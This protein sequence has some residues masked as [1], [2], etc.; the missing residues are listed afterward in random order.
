MWFL[1]F[2]IIFVGIFVLYFVSRRTITQ[3]TVTHIVSCQVPIDS[4]P[5]TDTLSP[6]YTINQGLNSGRFYDAFHDWTVSAINPDTLPNAE[7]LCSDFCPQLILPTTCILKDDI[8][9]SCISY[10]QNN[11]CNQ[12]ITPVAKHNNEYFYPI[13]RGRVSC[14]EYH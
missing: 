10:L 9:N 8:Y 1:L 4:L 5:D 11:D 13:G 14:Y 7:Q 12:S 2:I 3:D 6:C